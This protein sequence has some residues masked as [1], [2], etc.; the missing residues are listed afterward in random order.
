MSTVHR[1]THTH[2]SYTLTCIAEY[3]RSRQ[4]QYIVIRIPCHAGNIRRLVRAAEIATEIHA[5][6]GEI[7]HYDYV[8]FGSET[9]DDLKFLLSEICPCRIIRIGVYHGRDASGF[10]L[11]FQSTLQ[12]LAA[13]IIDVERLR[14]QPQ[15]LCLI[16]LCRES[17]IEHQQR[18][19]LLQTLLEKKH[20]SE[21]SLHGAHGWNNPLCRDIE[22][23]KC[24]DEF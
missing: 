11:L 4:E 23:K 3:F 6:I 20:Q 16:P 12:S 18:I 7:L 13:I 21:T 1:R 22:I 17:G 10:H 5:H 14:A 8:I 15:Q 24:L 19:L 9:A 2:E